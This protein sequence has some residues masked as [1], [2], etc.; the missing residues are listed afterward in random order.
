MGVRYVPGE[1]LEFFL[2]LCGEEPLRTVW[3]EDISGLD[4]V[5]EGRVL[6]A[7]Q[8][9]PSR[10]R[11]RRL[12]FGSEPP[13]FQR[14]GMSSLS[15]LDSLPRHSQL[16]IN[17]RT[18]RASRLDAVFSISEL[19]TD[20]SGPLQGRDKRVLSVAELE[21]AQREGCSSSRVGLATTALRAAVLVLAGLIALLTLRRWRRSRR[22]PAP[23]SA[24]GGLSPP[25]RR[26]GAVPSE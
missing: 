2:P 12:S 23:T 22:P 21:D 20:G 24:E 13:G 19:P 8:A 10:E 14:Q 18:D 6:W 15:E 3:L 25:A 5:G 4:K 7:V 17:A 11:I 9:S 1:S 16:P 26:A